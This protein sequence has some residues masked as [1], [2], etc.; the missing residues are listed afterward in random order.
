MTAKNNRRSNRRAIVVKSFDEMER[1]LA[2]E[3]AYQGPRP[4]LAEQNAMLAEMG[5]ACGVYGEDEPVASYP[6]EACEDAGQPAGQRTARLLASYEQ[7]YLYGI[8]GTY[9]KS[10]G[11]AYRDM[12]ATTAAAA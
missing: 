12:L 6:S 1:E 3:A 11:V 8:G 5:L 9:A 10:P 2:L 4:S 7:A